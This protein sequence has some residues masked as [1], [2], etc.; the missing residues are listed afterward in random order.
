[1]LPLS[2]LIGRDITLVRVIDFGSFL[3][4]YPNSMLCVTQSVQY[5]LMK[6]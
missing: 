1:M 5:L 4:N 3:D 2:F 6:L